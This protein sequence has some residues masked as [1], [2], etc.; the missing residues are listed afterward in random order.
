MIDMY[1]I[2]LTNS[3]NQTFN[4]TIPINGENKT[5]IV[6]LW[7]NYQAEYWLMS[8]TDSRTEQILVSNIPLLSSTYDFANILRQLGYKEI[9]NAYVVPIYDTSLSMPNN[10]NIGSDFALMWGDNSYV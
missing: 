8:L 4:T 1:K 2:P 7:Y 10:E 3:P 5:F 9:G 6:N